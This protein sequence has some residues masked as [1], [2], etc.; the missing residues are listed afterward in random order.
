MDQTKNLLRVLFVD[1]EEVFR[2]IM[3]RRVASWGYDVITAKDGKEAL[4]LLVEK[5]PDIIILDYMM[6]EMDGI[7]TLAQIRKVN[8]DIAVI[9]FTAYPDQHAIKG[10]ESFCIDAF[11]PKLSAY[12][13]TQAALRAALN[14]VSKKKAR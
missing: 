13:D 7:Q 9:M 3:S 1:D 5:E 14:L 12:S 10:A 11:V 8:R 4:N 6:P 2:E